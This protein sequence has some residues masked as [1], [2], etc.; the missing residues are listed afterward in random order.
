M[1]NQEEH[2]MK[3]SIC[4]DLNEEHPTDYP[5]AAVNQAER[6]ITLTDMNGIVLDSLTVCIVCLQDV[7]VTKSGLSF[8]F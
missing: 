1:L 5:L 4:K 6:H 8:T 3:C 7:R 2:T